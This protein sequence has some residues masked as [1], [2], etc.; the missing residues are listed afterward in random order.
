MEK[1]P[2]FPRRRCP[3]VFFLYHCYSELVHF[4]CGLHL[5]FKITLDLGS[6]I[7]LY[8]WNPMTKDLKFTSICFEIFQDFPVYFIRKY[9]ILNYT[10]TRIYWSS[11]KN[12]KEK[13]LQCNNISIS[14]WIKVNKTHL[15]LL[16]IL[17]LAFLF[18]LGEGQDVTGD[19]TTPWKETTLPTIISCYNSCDIYNAVEL[20]LFYKALPTKRYPFENREM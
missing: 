2:V 16:Q 18:Y 12:L 9:F 5:D 17:K 14:H 20:G 19:V 7:F 13:F 8:S 15:K 11:I 10:L 4:V 3:I 1:Q 6:H